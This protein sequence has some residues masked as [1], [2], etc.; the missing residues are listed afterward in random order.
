MDILSGQSQTH[1]DVWRTL[2][3][4]TDQS[5]VPC[6]GMTLWWSLFLSGYLGSFVPFRTSKFE[7]PRTI[8]SLN[9]TFL[10]PKKGNV[11]EPIRRLVNSKGVPLSSVEIG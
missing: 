6:V 9:F 3:P 7:L 2:I 5:Q 4:H 10:V 11:E 8:I 1:A